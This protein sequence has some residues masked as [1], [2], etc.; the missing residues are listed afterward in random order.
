MDVVE[1]R[2]NDY[3]GIFQYSSL[4]REDFEL[5]DTDEGKVLSIDT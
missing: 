2:Y 1:H 5:P 3:L 4:N